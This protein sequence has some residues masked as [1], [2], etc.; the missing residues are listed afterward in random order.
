MIFNPKRT[1]EYVRGVRPPVPG[2][3]VETMCK[4]NQVLTRNLHKKYS[5]DGLV[6]LFLDSANDSVQQMLSEILSSDRVDFTTPVI[7][8]NQSV[9][10]WVIAFKKYPRMTRGLPSHYMHILIH[11]LVTKRPWSKKDIP[12]MKGL[13]KCMFDKHMKKF[14]AINHSLSKFGDDPINFD[15]Y[16]ERY[17]T[18]VPC[19]HC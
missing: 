6:R 17:V 16:Y 11:G 15:S 7:Y 9:E 13:F 14:H 3:S 18:C 4:L 12:M 10:P 1:I 19:I 8:K 5:G 2:T